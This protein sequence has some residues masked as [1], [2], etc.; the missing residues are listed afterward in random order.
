MSQ[1]PRTLLSPNF[2]LEELTF[3]RDHPHIRNMPMGADLDHLRSTALKMEEV[4]L[5]LGHPIDVDSGYR[6]PELNLAVRGV[7]TSAHCEG[8]A[9]DFTCPGFGTPLAVADRIVASM[10]K[11]DQ[12]ILEYGWVHISFDP[13]LR[14]QC[15]TKRSAEDPYEHG[16]N[17]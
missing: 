9:V 16:I 8:Y 2:S 10:V 6:S 1:E 12:L 17:A 13:R 15:L 11:Y 14:M 3:S 7:V 5:L 4:R